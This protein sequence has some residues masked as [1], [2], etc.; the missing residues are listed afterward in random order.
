[1]P[2][3]IVGE[4]SVFE[5]VGS[6]VEIGDYKTLK[7]VGA[8]VNFNDTSSG[9]TFAKDYFKSGT[10]FGDFAGAST[11]KQDG[12]ASGSVNYKTTSDEV[13]YTMKYN[14]SSEPI[15]THPDF[16][17]FAGNGEQ[18]LHGAQFEANGVFRKFSH[19]LA[20]EEVGTLSLDG[21][22]SFTYPV[23]NA[24]GEAA[25]EGD[26]NWFS[27]VSSYL[28]T[29]GVWTK[30][31]KSSRAPTLAGLGKISTPDG[32]CPV[33]EG[34]NW[35]YTGFT[36]SFTSPAK[37]DQNRTIKGDITMEWPLSGRRG[38]DNDIY[39][40]SA[41]EGGDDVP[42]NSNEAFD[43]ID[44]HQDLQGEVLRPGLNE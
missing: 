43:G 26:Q 36:A 28:E 13:I 5:T 22:E 8:T 35:L 32:N 4:K 16:E 7:A 15:D 37:G 29:S 11:T 27:G 23:R 18:P 31:F 24:K 2:T 44:A 17:K 12:V 34:R 20:A 3:T 6:S 42:L 25:V 14:T 33:I 9:V 30:S 40:V 19:K 10:V 38:W 39:G 21:G 1:M 41:P